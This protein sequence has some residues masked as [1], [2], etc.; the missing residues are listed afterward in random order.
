MNIH[1]KL[2]LSWRNGTL[3]LIQ[4]GLFL[5][6]YDQ[7]LFLLVRFFYPALKV[8]GKSYKNLQGQA[9]LYGGFPKNK[10]EALFSGIAQH[11]TEWGIEVPCDEINENEYQIWRQQQ[12]MNIEESLNTQKVEAVLNLTEKT[13]DLFPNSAPG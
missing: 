1:D 4:E 11:K 8:C 7:S 9:V 10:L 13:I 2:A 5:R 6:C 12:I 3:A